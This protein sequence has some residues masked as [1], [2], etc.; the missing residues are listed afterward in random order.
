[1]TDASTVR[2][3]SG[4]TGGAERGCVLIANGNSDETH[5]PIQR[6]KKSF[7]NLFLGDGHILTLKIRREN[8]ELC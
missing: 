2:S 4:Q 5:H 8:S 7:K 6:V 1:M 3:P